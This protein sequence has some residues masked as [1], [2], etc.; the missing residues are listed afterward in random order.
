MSDT[1]HIG[2]PGG[3]PR[4]DTRKLRDQW[5]KARVTADEKHRAEQL[6]RDANKTESDFV[7][8][9]VLEGQIVIRRQRTVAPILLH[10]LGRL[11]QELSRA[12]NVVN[13]ALMIAHT[14]G[15]LRRTHMLEAAV[16]DITSA[17]AEIRPLLKR[18]HE[19]E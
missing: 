18:L 16:A 17:V 15:N 7:R 3:R 1:T 6:M 10:D 14:T 11:A 9:A 8:G 19:L 12:G 4:K 5:L 13:Q 2:Q